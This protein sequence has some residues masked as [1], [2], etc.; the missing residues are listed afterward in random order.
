ME[1]TRTT[2]P[3]SFLWVAS[4][5]SSSSK[6]RMMSRDA[7]RY[8]SPALVSRSGRRS[9]STNPTPVSFS[10]S[11]ALARGGLADLIELGR[12]GDRPRL[13]DVAEDFQ[14]RYGY[15]VHV[16]SITYFGPLNQGRWRERYLG[17]SRGNPRNRSLTV[18]ALGGASSSRNRPLVAAHAGEF[19]AVAGLTGELVEAHLAGR[20]LVDEV[21]RVSRRA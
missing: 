13:R 9:R 3:V 2:L 15:V 14:M 10:S 8:I 21:A 16:I 12:M 1:A 17:R 20:M 4:C 18:A 7:S 5:D 11:Q 6:R 19:S